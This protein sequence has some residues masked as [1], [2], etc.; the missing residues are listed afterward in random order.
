MISIQDSN[1]RWRTFLQEQYTREIQVL[2]SSWPTNQVLTI[3]FSDIQAWDPNF[4]QS[5]IEYPKPIL[6]A[7]TES[8]RALCAEGGWEIDPTL[9][10]IELPHDCKKSLREVGSDY[11][12][13]LI[14]SEVVVTKVSE[15]KPRIYNASFRCFICNSI[16]EIQQENELELIEP[17]NCDDLNG[18]CG[19]SV[20]GGKDATKF[21]LIHENVTLVD[22]Q[23]IEIQELPENVT[24]G[25]QPARATVLAEADLANVLLPGMRVTVNMV[26]FIRSEKTRGSKTPMFN[27]YYSLMSVEYENTPFNEI[28]ISEED[29]ELINQISKR[30]DLQELL[31]NSIAPSIFG[32]GK[33]Q[34]VKRSLVMQLFSG[35]S[36]RYSDGTRAR[37]DI[38]ILLMGDPGVAKSQLLTYM[39]QISPRGKYASGGGISGAGLTAAAV[40][41]A[42]NDGRFSLEAGLLVLADSGLAAIDEFDKMNTDDR[43]RMHEAM[44]QQKI[45]ISKG[46]INATMRTRCAVLAAANPEQGRFSN[47]SQAGYDISPLFEEVKLPPALISRF[48]IIW[49]LRDDIIKEQDTQIAEHILSNRS[50][51]VSEILIEEGRVMDPKIVD[52]ESVMKKGYSGEDQLTIPTFRKYVAWA[53]RTIHPT[54]TPDAKDRITNFYIDTRSKFHEDD[55]SVPITARALEGLV[56]LAEARA[57]TR[58]SQEATDEDAKYA[59]ALFN[60]WRYE[61]QGDEFDEGLIL[62]G[63]P[64]KK[65]SAEQHTLNVI[66][67]LSE[68]KQDFD[69]PTGDILNEMARLNFDEHE[70]E[71]ALK[72]LSLRSQIYTPGAGRWRFVN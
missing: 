13:S 36:R 39:S 54:L 64:A 26:P 63:R 15:L 65:R 5:L 67:Q 24:G 45:H 37:G 7:A 42:F 70:V 22:N 47:R 34:M 9:R 8:L 6:R 55:N 17:I 1:A 4:A 14:S 57:R 46:G 31:A 10:I 48:D 32:A 29:I 69:V 72:Q 58:L 56:R 23:W 43:S 53:K 27:V 35:V 16:T 41:D 44:E 2:A 11:I 60:N 52:D 50:T 51:G 20:G 61:L 18:G 59:I 28:E 30:E 38:H 62:T 68:G 3:N 19:R 66:N 40:K 25:A 21:E 71:D 49:L 33:L 12:G